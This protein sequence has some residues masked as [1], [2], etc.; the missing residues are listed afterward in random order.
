MSEKTPT[1][2]GEKVQITTIRLK[3]DLYAEL[4]RISKRSGLTVTALIIISIWNSVLEL[5]WLRL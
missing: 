4:E 5:K 3:D 2:V 1:I